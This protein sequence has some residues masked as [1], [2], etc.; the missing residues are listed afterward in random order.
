MEKSHAELENI[1]K[2]ESGKKKYTKPM[3]EH[4]DPLESVSQ[5]Y[6]Y[7]YYTYLF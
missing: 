4:H 2:Q 1:Q 6:Y 3:F 5:T 7:Y